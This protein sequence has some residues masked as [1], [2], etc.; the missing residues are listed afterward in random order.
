MQLSLT[1]VIVA[2]T[3]LVS[4]RAFNDRALMERMILWPP[5]VERRKQYDRLLGYGFVH[6]DWMHLAFNMITLWSF[7]SAVEREFSAM[8]TPVGYVLFYLSAIV[9]SILPTYLAHRNDPHYRSLGASGGVS[10]VLFAFILFDPWST[11]I[12]FPIPVPIPAFLFAILYVAYSIWMD[13]RG[14]DNVNHSAHL[15]GAAYGVLF[16]VLLEPRILGHFTQSLLG[17]ATP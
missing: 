6:A 16:T 13:R 15:W 5:A 4:W 9:V 2:I 7:G 10:A 14:R 8:I 11:L 3:V 1:I 17:S 12:I